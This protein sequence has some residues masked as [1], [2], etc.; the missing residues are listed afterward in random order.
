MHSELTPEEASFLFEVEDQNTDAPQTATAI[1]FARLF[2]YAHRSN[3]DP[4]DFEI[5]RGLREHAGLRSGYSTLMQNMAIAYSNM[6]AAASSD[7]YPMRELGFYSLTLIEDHGDYFIELVFDDADDEKVVADEIKDPNALVFLGQ[8]GDLLTYELGPLVKGVRMII[9]DDMATK[10]RR[11]LE[12][13]RSTTTGIF[14]TSGDNE[15]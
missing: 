12:L 4:L 5:E 9:L 14:L 15:D 10:D 13:L 2:G 6:A 1:T 3:S 11:L 8:N 7:E